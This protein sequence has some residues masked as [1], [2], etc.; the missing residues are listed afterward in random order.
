MK[1]IA[2]YA[3]TS[4]LAVLSSCL[5]MLP[6]LG[7]SPTNVDATLAK[8]QANLPVAENVLNTLSP[9]IETLDPSSA[10]VIKPLVAQIDADIPLVSQAITA[11]LANPSADQLA[12]I[13]TSINAIVSNGSASLL[14]ATHI[15]DPA[16][17]QKAVAAFSLLQ[18][19]LV[20]VDGLIQNIESPSVVKANAETRTVKLATLDP[21]LD[22][23]KLDQFA[24]ANGTTYRAFYQLEQRSGY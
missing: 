20:I 10:A 5:I 14:A 24:V 22:H 7:C 13:Q 16:S 9:I 8:I 1:A 21:Y 15:S 19:S 12:K 17:Q 11:Y 6:I 4:A 23:G 18:T 3:K 2:L